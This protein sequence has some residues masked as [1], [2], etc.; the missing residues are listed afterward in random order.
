MV[1]ARNPTANRHSVQYWANLESALPRMSAKNYSS[2]S[3]KEEPVVADI[4]GP[5]M[6]IQTFEVICQ[7][8]AK[9]QRDRNRQRLD[10]K[11]VAEIYSAK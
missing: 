3:S 4:G 8:M 7:R 5:R 1:S 10:T 2:L 9:T 11:V 6:Q